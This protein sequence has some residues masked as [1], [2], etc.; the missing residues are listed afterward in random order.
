MNELIDFDTR[1]LPTRHQLIRD[2]R[3]SAQRLAY[4][5]TDQAQ[6]MSYRRIVEVMQ[7]ELDAWKTKKPRGE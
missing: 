1:G 7:S 3:D 5:A 6:S 4:S 2:V